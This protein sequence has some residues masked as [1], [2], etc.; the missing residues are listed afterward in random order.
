[1]IQTFS[2]FLFDTQIDVQ[3]KNTDVLFLLFPL[4]QIVVGQKRKEKSTTANKG[5]A[6][7]RSVLGVNYRATVSGSFKTIC[8]RSY[9]INKSGLNLITTDFVKQLI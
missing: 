2:T 7:K 1:M 4:R 3:S 9:G 5:A 6:K 8:I